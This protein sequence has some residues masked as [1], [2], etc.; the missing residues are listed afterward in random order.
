MKLFGALEPLRLAL[1]DVT[2]ML[3]GKIPGNARVANGVVE[4]VTQVRESLCHRNRQFGFGHACVV[5]DVEPVSEVLLDLVVL[6]G[7]P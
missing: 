4:R 6:V 3:V 1:L 5:P 2:D 7:V